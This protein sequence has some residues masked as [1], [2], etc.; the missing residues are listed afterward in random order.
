MAAHEFCMSVMRSGGSGVPTGHGL[1][2]R[3]DYPPVE[4][5]GYCRWSLRDPWP[6]SSCRYYPLDDAGPVQVNV[7]WGEIS[8]RDRTA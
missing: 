4:L 5:A 8:F 3:T 2:R 7:G 6:W 1:V